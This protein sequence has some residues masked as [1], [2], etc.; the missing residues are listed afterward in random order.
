VIEPHT[1]VAGPAW[2]GAGTHVLGG[3][4]G[5]GVALGPMC[6]V[7]GEIEETIFQGYGN[8]RHHGFVGHSVVGAVGEPGRAHDDERP[9]E[10]LRPGA[11]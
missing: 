3:K 1:Y 5:G 7:A 8:K 10:Q 2:I 9:E 11:A 4:L 6:R